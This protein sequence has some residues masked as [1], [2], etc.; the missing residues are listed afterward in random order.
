MPA[1]VA[2]IVEWENA[3][4]S[5]LDRARR[6]LRQLADQAR[7]YAAARNTRFELI[8]IHNPDQVERAVPESALNGEI[9]PATWPGTIRILAAPGLHYYDQ[10]TFGAAQTDADVILFLDSDVI[11]DE[12]WLAKLL[13]GIDDPQTEVIGG[14]TYLTDESF[15]DRVFA[16]FWFFRP[17]QPRAGV[18]DSGGFYANNVAFKRS[19]FLAHPFPKADCYRGQCAQLSRTIKAE[20]VPIRTHGE[21][22]VSHPAPDGFLHAMKRA[23]AHGYD[24]VYW[25]RQTSN[26]WLTAS[27]AGALVRWVKGLIL[28]V[29]RVPARA[30][31]LELDP[32]T[33]IVSALT[34][35][36]FHTAIFASE[37]VSYFFPN[38]VRRHVHI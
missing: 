20:G 5:E 11:P 4:L 13:D 3:L 12:G 15:F 25:Q 6:M 21:A 27:P 26:G 1:T 24:S 33:A 22:F 17:K 34:G 31:H 18:F 38:L 36:V 16:G 7:A 30:W 14:Q 29:R 10:K 23:V 19:F 8:V 2:V 35:I 28:V 9:D 32:L 37:V